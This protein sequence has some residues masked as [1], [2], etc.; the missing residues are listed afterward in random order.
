[1]RQALTDLAR[2]LRFYSRLPVPRLPWE[3]DAHAPPD[4]GRVARALPVAGAVIGLVPALVLLASL[5]LGL[6]P[7]LAAALAVAA[8]TAATGAFHEDGLADTA[9]G[10]GGGATPER[11]LEIMKDSRIGS[12]GGAALSLGL[13][14][15]VATLAALA[16]RL[17]PGPA[18]AAVVIAA[19]LS[20]TSALALLALLPPARTEGSSYAV[21]CLTPRAFAVPAALAIGIALA[22]GL[23]ANL[24][25]PGLALAVVLPAGA[26]LLL[27]RLSARLI[28]GQTGDVAG[29]AQQAG[30]VACLLGLLIAVGP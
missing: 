17:D 3:T 23:P 9:D 11:R 4:F 26:T 30:E 10:F 12:F 25:L 15:R 22:L 24:P 18:A 21:G 13:I 20:R 6:G 28:G 29:A 2:S 7:L 27:A 14:L 16:G 19:S 5:K 8:L 1:M